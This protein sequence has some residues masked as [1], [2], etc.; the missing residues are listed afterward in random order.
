MHFWILPYSPF[1]DNRLNLCTWVSTLA[2]KPDMFTSISCVCWWCLYLKLLN[3]FLDFS[4]SKI[5]S[6]SSLF[7][8]SS[9]YLNIFINFIYLWECIGLMY[10]VL[11][12]LPFKGF[13]LFIYIF[14]YFFKWI[15]VNKLYLF[16]LKSSIIF[17][18]LD[19]RLFS[20]ILGIWGCTVL[21]FVGL[22]CYSSTI[23]PQFYW[24]HFF[25]VLRPS[26]SP[27]IPST[28]APC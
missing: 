10:L 16:L 22:L 26:G 12:F 17:I 13:Y 1:D 4:L 15:S 9:S 21:I 19:S 18:M 27:C 25:L 5:V 14:Y 2:S 20:Y 6:D 8:F 3:T 7:L 24:L 23:F 28:G 11:I